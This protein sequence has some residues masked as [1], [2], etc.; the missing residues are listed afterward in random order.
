MQY[1]NFWCRLQIRSVN[2]TCLTNRSSS[3][4]SFLALL[5][6]SSFDT[7]TCF[8]QCSPIALLYR[9]LD[10]SFGRQHIRHI[11]FPLIFHG[12]YPAERIKTA[13]SPPPLPQITYTNRVAKIPLPF[14]ATHVE[15]LSIRIEHS[16]IFHR[17]DTSVFVTERICQLFN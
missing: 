1:V 11:P 10:K 3:I 8:R 17:S 14:D 15:I 6:H 16:N 13:P 9:T 2:F 12:S 4:F 5:L 7:A